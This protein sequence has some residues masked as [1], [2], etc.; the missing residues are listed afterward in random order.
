[1]NK[2]N[3]LEEN[4]EEVRKLKAEG[5]THLEV[6]QYFSTDDLSISAVTVGNFCRKHR[7]I[8][9]GTRFTNLGERN[10]SK[11]PEVRNKISNTVTTLW[12]DGI[13]DNRVDGMLGKVGVLNP[14]FTFSAYSKNH[15]REKYLAYVE[16]NLVC[17]RCGKP[18]NNCKWDVHHIDEDHN[19]HLLTNLQALCVPC[20]GKFHLTEFNKNYKQSYVIV[21]RK[22]LLEC[23]HF[24][25]EYEG[26]CFW[27]H[28]HR[29]EVDI[30]VRRRID[31]DTG[32]VLDFH[33]FKDIVH[34]Y[35]ETPLD[36]SLLNDFLINPTSERFIILIWKI[37]SP[38][39]KGL[40]SI[41]LHESRDTAITINYEY[42]MELAN[43]GVIEYEWLL[44][45][46]DIISED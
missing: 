22:F 20:H 27:T 1:M 36:H 19:N 31:P 44:N 33:Q 3:I 5:K 12:S 30:E 45:G 14:R 28:G 16:D 18:L 25:P 10:P 17:E 15:Y 42:M 4:I 24:L 37:L 11:R 43:N 38:H 29:Y 23:A 35:L 21:S 26:K 40:Y 32:M 2:T 8:S 13:Y 7:I 6:A 9:L 41:K 46:E 34:K 39:L